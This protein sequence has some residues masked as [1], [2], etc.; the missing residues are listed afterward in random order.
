MS[1]GSH[2]AEHERMTLRKSL[3]LRNDFFVL[4]IRSIKFFN[5]LISIL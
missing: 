2:R 3:D 4:N 1:R 5:L